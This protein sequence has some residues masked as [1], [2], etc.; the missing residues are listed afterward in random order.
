[1]IWT[2][3]HYSHSVVILF[4]KFVPTIR[5]PFGLKAITIQPVQS[6]VKFGIEINHKHYS[7]SA[8]DVVHISSVTSITTGGMFRL[9]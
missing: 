4:V 2:S 9:T 1:L 6:D 3:I 5:R 8:L 7:D